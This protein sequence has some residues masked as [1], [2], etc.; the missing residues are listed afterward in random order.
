MSTAG[1]DAV[2]WLS[3][4]VT[5]PE[6]GVY[7]AFSA[8]ISAATHWLSKSQF[9]ASISATLIRVALGCIAMRAKLLGT[10][11]VLVWALGRVDTKFKFS[12]KVPQI[13]KKS[14]LAALPGLV[15]VGAVV[16][17]LL[18]SGAS[19]RA[20]LALLLLA[21]VR[22]FYGLMLQPEKDLPSSFPV[23]RT[24]YMFV[25]IVIGALEMSVGTACHSL[26]LEGDSWHM[27]LDATAMGLGS[28]FNGKGMRAKVKFTQYVLLLLAAV[29][30]AV[31]SA[32][33]VAFGVES[34]SAGPVLC[35]AVL[36]LFL[37]IEGMYMLGTTKLGPVWWHL[38]ADLAGSLL[39]LTAAGM[40]ALDARL[41]LLDPLAASLIAFALFTIGARKLRKY[42][43]H[44]SS[45]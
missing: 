13:Y 34:L 19:S 10:V 35:V 30:L 16:P 40:I 18:S 1:V 20:A 25:S 33:R 28:V 7:F 6:L 26:A 3:G 9:R 15:L 45:A 23:Y 39:A 4:K 42:L 29:N 36:G 22:E 37:N 41:W 31:H 11:C 38:I 2:L 24:R 12:Q 21:G 14:A 44:E 27:L 17:L 5:N 43:Y 8:L 32:I